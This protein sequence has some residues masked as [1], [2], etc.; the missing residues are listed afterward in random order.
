MYIG[1]SLTIVKK[2]ERHMYD[3]HCRAAGTRLG[4]EGVR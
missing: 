1:R 2:P 4:Q 3:A